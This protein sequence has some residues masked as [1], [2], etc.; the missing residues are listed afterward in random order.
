MSSNILPRQSAFVGLFAAV[1]FAASP[2][3]QATEYSCKVGSCPFEA[4]C[5]GNYWEQV[6]ACKIR[7]F[8]LGGNGQIIPQ[9]TA[10]CNLEA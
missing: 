5:D 7:C 3:I 8:N 2:V 9:G 6:S 10:Q 1:L 4:T